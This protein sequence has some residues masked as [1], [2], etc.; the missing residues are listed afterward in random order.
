MTSGIVSGVHRRN[1]GIARYEDFVQTDA[2]IYPG[3]SGGALVNGRGDLVGINTAFIGPA[4]GNPGLG[5]AI[6][7]EMVRSV[8]AEILEHGEFRH[9][10]LGITFEDPA[11]GHGR[12]VKLASRRTGAV[13]VA[14]DKGSPAEH[15]GLRS[16]DVVTELGRVPVQ[17]TA[18]LH[19]RLGLFRVG[20][21]AEL[22]VSREGIAMNV[23]AVIAE[24]ERHTRSK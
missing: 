4:R 8:A 22:T 24:P 18:E 15:A 19:F 23:R 10:E 20:D 11:R 3:N 9:G 13:V 17:D 1:V 14:V 16:G 12:D 2:A 5:F 21:V 6:P 7:I